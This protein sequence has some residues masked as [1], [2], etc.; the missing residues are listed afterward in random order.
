[1]GSMVACHVG[2]PGLNPIRPWNYYNAKSSEPK[3]VKSRVRNAHLC[4]GRVR[5]TVRK[6][7][8]MRRKNKCGLMILTLVKPICDK[9]IN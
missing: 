8:Q 1:M 5:A 6:L 4:P 9:K 2:D 3:T 7:R